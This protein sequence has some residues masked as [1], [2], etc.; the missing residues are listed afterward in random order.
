ML[1]DLTLFTIS[2]YI[3]KRAW[4]FL[5]LD[6]NEICYL[7]LILADS[8]EAV[9]RHI[10]KNLDKYKFMLY[11][12]IEECLEVLRMNNFNLQIYDEYMS[13]MCK[14]VCAVIIDKKNY[15]AQNGGYMLNWFEDRD[16]VISIIKE[17]MNNFD[18]NQFHFCRE[19]ALNKNHYTFIGI[20]EFDSDDISIV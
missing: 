6:D 1:D 17:K 3:K 14:E 19:Y 20:I 11:T 8:E 5:I 15:V 4:T 7:K 2:K 13:E 16:W 12:L 18:I 10:K 9:I